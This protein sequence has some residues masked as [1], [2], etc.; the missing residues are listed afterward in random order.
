MTKEAYNDG[1]QIYKRKIK[2][3]ETYKNV[4]KEDY[5]KS[6]K[7]CNVGDL[8]DITLGSGR[9]VK[10]AEVKTLGILKDKKVC[11]T[12]YKKDS[13]IK[14]ITTPHLEITIKNK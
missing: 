9:L 12:S 13:K 7:P 1:I 2:E 6:N 3:A 8:V 5:I 4:L 14:Y 10:N 11:I